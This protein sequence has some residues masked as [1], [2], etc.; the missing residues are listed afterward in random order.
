MSLK[1]LPINIPCNGIDI[2]KEASVHNYN[3]NITKALQKKLEATKRNTNIEY[4]FT[5]GGIVITADAVTFEL[6]RIATLNYFET[7]PE[8][9]GQI[10]ITK[11]TDKT[12]SAVVQHT[13]K[14]TLGNFS[15]TANIYNT[16]SRLLINGNGTNQFMHK[17][18]PAIHKIV[19]QGLRQQGIKGLNIEGL[20]QKLGSQLQNLLNNDLPQENNSRQLLSIGNDATCIKCH[21]KCRTRSTFCNTGN[22][23]IH[24]KCQKLSEHEVYV[25]ENSKADEHYECKICREAN[26]NSLEENQD[27][28]QAQQ[29]LDEETELM[30]VDN[31]NEQTPNT[32]PTN[33]QNCAVC[34]NR[35]NGIDW[36]ICNFCNNNC[37]SKCLTEINETP[38]C[39]ACTIVQEEI[40]QQEDMSKNHENT[41]SIGTPTV[42]S[43]KPKI[44]PIPKPRKPR[45]QQNLGDPARVKL[46]DL[47]TREIKMKKAEDQLKMKE[48]SL[49]EFKNEKIMLETRCQHLEARNFELEQ[50]VKLLKRRMESNNDIAMPYTSNISEP[51]HKNDDVFSTMKQQLDQKLGKL[52]TKLSTIVIDEMERQLDKI[53]FFDDNPRIDAGSEPERPVDAGQSEIILNNKENENINWKTHRITQD[54]IGQPLIYKQQPNQEVQLQHGHYQNTLPS[55]Q[56]PNYSR[57]MQLGGK[58]NHCHQQVRPN[59]T[60]NP[61][62]HTVQAQSGNRP[63]TYSP[64]QQPFLAQQSLH[65]NRT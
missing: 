65:L 34:D 7:L 62:I 49:Q 3:L 14:V 18:L 13:I 23:W 61:A 1:L 42:V 22:H 59:T 36:D 44:K 33:I 56:R 40:K 20:N 58:R 53:K 28:T 48:K 50:T 47:R 52:H 57:S 26:M 24:Y 41:V 31:V 30:K 29:L 8:P 45:I 38:I 39:I 4:N 19:I 12:Q 32:P 63:T 37:H 51:S 10:N 9:K 46:G 55:A 35:I 21:K 64:T 17:D 60:P 2:N 25:A 54:F 11:T 6:I 15:Y 43:E 27:Q 16:T 5:N